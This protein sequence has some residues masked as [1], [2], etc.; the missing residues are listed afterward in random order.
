MATPLAF[1]GRSAH[2][3]AAVREAFS[4]EQYWKDR[5][6]TVGG[7]NARIESLAIAGDQVRVELVQ[8]IPAEDLPKQITA[9][10]PEGLVIPRTEIWTGDA[11][12]FTA[13]VEGAP[14]EVRGTL[15][16]TEDGTGSRYVVDGSIE[17]SIPLFGKKIE[18]A[19]QEN[20]TD[21]LVREAEFTDNWLSSH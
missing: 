9:I 6:E 13:R 3:A 5:I 10:K 4:N 2:S 7:V 20:L 14:A 1:T 21:L 15:T 17:V 8:T 11:G 18:A 19:I 12:T 16:L